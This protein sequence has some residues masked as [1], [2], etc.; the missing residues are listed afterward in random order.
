LPVSSPPRGSTA[1]CRGDSGKPRILAAFTVLVLLC[2]P[3]SAPAEIL[4][5]YSTGVD[6]DGDVLTAGTIDP[7]YELISGPA[8][9]GSSVLAQSTPSFWSAPP[10]GSSWVSVVDSGGPAVPMGDYV[11]ETT[12]QIQNVDLTNVVLT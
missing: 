12:F 4:G 7:H 2:S 3:N 9:V 5:L 1:Q 6:D 10:E 8:G 11:F